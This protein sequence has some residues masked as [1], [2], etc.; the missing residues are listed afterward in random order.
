MSKRKLN[1]RFHN[2]NTVEETAD[3]LYKVFLKANEDKV[4]RKIREVSSKVSNNDEYIIE[5]RPA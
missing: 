2:P 5:G 3:I 4:E 1:Y